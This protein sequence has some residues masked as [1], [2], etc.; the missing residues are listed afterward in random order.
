M[1]SKRGQLGRHFSLRKCKQR[2]LVV[3]RI[4]QNKNILPFTDLNHYE[5]N[6]S[7]QRSTGTRTK[8]PGT[9][10]GTFP[11]EPGTKMFQKIGNGRE[12]GTKNLRNR[13]PG[14]NWERNF[15]KNRERAGI[16]NI[17]F[18]KIGN[19]A[20]TGNMIFENHREDGNGRVPDIGSRRSLVGVLLE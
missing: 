14:G 1:E 9:F 20:G 3:M 6:R 15:W 7:G 16:G 10:P 12:P 8:K 2:G 5:T 18:L 13:E 19:R 4:S 17:F 11:R